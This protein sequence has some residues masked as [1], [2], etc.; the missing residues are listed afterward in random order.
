M[1]RSRLNAA[2][3]GQ[4]DGSKDRPCAVI[5]AVTETDGR[6]RAL[7]CAITHSEPQL[8]EGVEIPAAIKRH[9]GLDSDRSWIILSEF[10]EIDWTD[11]GIIPARPNQWV[12]GF[13]PAPFA[14]KLR[15]LARTKIM[16]ARAT[17]TRRKP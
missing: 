5:V 3:R 16:E 4:I 8:H 15:D 10:N 7:V 9:L 2:R 1:P 11:P 12:Y 17:I 13:V 6:K 14:E